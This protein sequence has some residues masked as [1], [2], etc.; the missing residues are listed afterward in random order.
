MLAHRKGA[1]QISPFLPKTYLSVVLLN[2]FHLCYYFSFSTYRP[3]DW[4]AR[5]RAHTHTHTHS[6]WCVSVIVI[7]GR[8]VGYQLGKAPTYLR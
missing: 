8:T 3:M 7:A 5:A 6:Y 2:T 1:A 4:R